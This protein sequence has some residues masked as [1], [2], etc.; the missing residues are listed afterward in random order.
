[1]LIIGAEKISIDCKD[2]Q[3]RGTCI[4]FGDGAGAM[5][6]GNTDGGHPVLGI[7]LGADGSG[8]EAL[9]VPAGGARMPATHETVDAR[10]HYLKMDGKEVFKRA[11][12]NDVRCLEKNA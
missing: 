8:A 10:M 11:I 9:Y 3:D 7:S 6:L 2:W 5:V 4:L 1:V 12:G